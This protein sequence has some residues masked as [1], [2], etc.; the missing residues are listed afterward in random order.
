MKT[1][2]EKLIEQTS[3]QLEKDWRNDQER[4]KAK[5]QDGDIAD[6]DA[7]GVIVVIP[8]VGEEVGDG[9]VHANTY[10]MDANSKHI[11]WYQPVKNAITFLCKALFV[12]REENP[13]MKKRNVTAVQWFMVAKIQ[14]KEWFETNAFA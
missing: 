9:E 12:L 10:D 13:E 6:A 8:E 11:S 1:A 4:D 3:V 14:V 7:D 5:E 2:F